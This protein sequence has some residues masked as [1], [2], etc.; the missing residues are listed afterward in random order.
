MQV[1]HGTTS[2]T[3]KLQPIV[4]DLGNRF[5][6]LAKYRLVVIDTPGFDSTRNTNDSEILRGIS[7][8]LTAS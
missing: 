6:H 1:G 4:L 7:K 8:W 2:Y 5:P 3:E